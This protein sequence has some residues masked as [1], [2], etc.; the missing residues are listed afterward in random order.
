MT[1]ERNGSARLAAGAIVLAATGG[2]SGVVQAEEYG[3]MPGRGGDPSSLPTLSVDVGYKPIEGGGLTGGRVNY[4]IDERT[5]VF[6]EIATYKAE[7]DAGGVTFEVS[8]QPIGA[9]VFYHLPDAAESVDVS[10][11]A[12]YHTAD[13]DLDLVGASRNESSSDLTELF[14]GVVF[15]GKEPISENGLRWF[16]SLAYGQ[17]KGDIDI[18]VAGG[19]ESARRTVNADQSGLSFSLGVLL[20]IELGELYAGYESFDGEGGGALGFRYFVQ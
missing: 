17:I 7:V 19:G 8:G 2:L 4:R 11:V 14:A 3:L 18:D 20:P 6:A 16:G 9:G 13:L 5:T 10:I 1:K 12:S 15:G